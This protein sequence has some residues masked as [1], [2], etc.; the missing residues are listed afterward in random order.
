MI[1]QGKNQDEIAITIMGLT[2]HLMSM[3]E[4][5]GQTMTTFSELSLNKLKK[6]Q[7]F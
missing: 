2:H 1:L 7:L 6:A 4:Q 3:V 5:V